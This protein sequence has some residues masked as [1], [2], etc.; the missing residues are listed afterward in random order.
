MFD[1]IFSCLDTIHQRD[2]R[3]DGLTDTGRQQRPR[4]RTASR[5]K[6]VSACL[7]SFPIDSG[8][9]PYNSLTMF[10]GNE[11]NTVA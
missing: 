9:S 2:G 3:T 11:L 6:Y 5:G 8:R 10:I 7:V 1:D 4:L